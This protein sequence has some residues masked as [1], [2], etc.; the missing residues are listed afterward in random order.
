M[1]EGWVENPN[2]QQQSV[3]DARWVKKNGINHY[4]YKN[5]IYMD[6]K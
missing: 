5:S 4:G 2:R 6:V 1:P 3:L